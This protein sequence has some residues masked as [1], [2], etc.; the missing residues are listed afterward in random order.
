MK[1]TLPATG[2]IRSAKHT[3][4]FTIGG[5]WMGL[6][7]SCSDMEFLMFNEDKDGNYP[8]YIG[9]RAI[10]KRNPDRNLDRNDTIIGYVVDTNDAIENGADLVYVLYDIFEV[11]E[12][13]NELKGNIM[14]AMGPKTIIT[15]SKMN[16]L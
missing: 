13:V 12:L 4:I 8:I 14:A 2:A 3:P 6:I 7:E 5:M 11:V 10:V 15:R 1:K 16:P 9:I